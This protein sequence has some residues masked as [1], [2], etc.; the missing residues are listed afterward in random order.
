MRQASSA[1]LIWILVECTGT[2]D[3]GM[4]QTSVV[5]WL[6][7]RVG[8]NVGW[9]IHVWR[10][11]WGHDHTIANAWKS[12]KGVIGEGHG[13]L[14]MEERGWRWSMD[15]DDRPGRDVWMSVG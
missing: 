3:R 6:N 14:V 9:S 7:V 10:R 15:I 8:Q 4:E 1:G 5:D 12:S 13:P 11:E 2:M